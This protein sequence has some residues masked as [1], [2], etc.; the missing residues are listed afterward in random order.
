MEELKEFEYLEKDAKDAPVK[1]IAWKG[2]DIEFSSRLEDNKKGRPIILRCFDFTAPPGV[3][4]PSEQ[5]L[6]DFHKKQ[7]DIFL[8]KDSIVRIDDLKVV[9]DKNKY[10]IFATCQGKM[11]AVLLEKPLAIQDYASSQHMD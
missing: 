6:A 3:E 2:K 9:I 7:I 10:K 1:D 11:G 5:E 4:L 8:W